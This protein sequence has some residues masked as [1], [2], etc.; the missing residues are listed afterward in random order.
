MQTGDISSAVILFVIVA[1]VLVILV[2][3]GVRLI[4][5]LL[6]TPKSADKSKGG[7]LSGKY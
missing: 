6:V 4:V 5:K 3:L 1:I 2:F 7:G